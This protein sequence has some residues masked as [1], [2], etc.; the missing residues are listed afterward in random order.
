M[1][2]VLFLITHVPLHHSVVLIDRLIDKL[3]IEQWE[4]MISYLN[5]LVAY[6]SLEGRFTYMKINNW[7]IRKYDKSFSVLISIDE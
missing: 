6:E 1:N 4:I 2:R 5:Y 7:Y 3:F